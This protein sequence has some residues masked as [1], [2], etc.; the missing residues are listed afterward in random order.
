MIPILLIIFIGQAGII[1][2]QQIQFR[3][4]E[5][6]TREAQKIETRLT[7]IGAIAMCIDRSIEKE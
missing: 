2:T 5:S 6:C 1:E 7:D 4:I 3:T